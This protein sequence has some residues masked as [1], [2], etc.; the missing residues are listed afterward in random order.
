MFTV[1]MDLDRRAYF[2]SATIVIAVPTGIK[3]FRW[4]ATMWGS[5]LPKVGLTL[6]VRGF[7]IMFTVGGVTGVVLSNRL[8]DLNL[9]DTY[10]VVAHFHYVL[11]LGAVYGLVTGT[12]LCFSLFMG[13]NMNT[14]TQVITFCLLFTGTNVTFMP[15]H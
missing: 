12:S 10:Y 11:R 2:T 13:T 5:S 14:T 9:H 1:G 4:L 7:I 15:L 8:I 3:V 6:W